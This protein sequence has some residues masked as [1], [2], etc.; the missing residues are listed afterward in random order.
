MKKIYKQ[1]NLTARSYHKILK[2]ARTLADM[3][4]SENILDAHLNEVQS[5]IAILIKDS[6]GIRYEISVLAFKYSGSRL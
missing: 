3:D 6:G 1:L 4:A 5:A 2:V